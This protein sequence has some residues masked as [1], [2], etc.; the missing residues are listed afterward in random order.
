ML[1]RSKGFFAVYLWRDP[2]RKGVF[3]MIGSRFKIA[4]ALLTAAAFLFGGSMAYAASPDVA[5][6]LTFSMLTH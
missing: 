2:F 3:N 5:P 4:A 6:S 1:F